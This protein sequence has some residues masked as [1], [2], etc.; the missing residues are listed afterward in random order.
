MTTGAKTIQP[1]EFQAR[2]QKAKALM[3]AQDMDARYLNAGASLLYF[4]GTH[5]RPSERLVGAML[6]PDGAPLYIAPAFEKGTLEQFTR[7]EGEIITWEEHENPY[8][9]LTYQFDFTSGKVC[10]L[11]TSPSP[12]DATLSRMPS[13]A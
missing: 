11:Y 8:Q 6:F 10:L 4:T 12:R 2:I 5:W 3:R 7:I 13:S 9:K 1:H